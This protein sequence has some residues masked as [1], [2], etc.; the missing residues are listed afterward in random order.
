M[1]HHN[2]SYQERKTNKQDM[3]ITRKT[4]AKIPRQDTPNSVCVR[5]RGVVALGSREVVVVVMKVEIV[6]MG[7]GGGDSEC[8]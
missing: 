5:S 7:G 4:H 3:N 1:K 8:E 6:V 2:T